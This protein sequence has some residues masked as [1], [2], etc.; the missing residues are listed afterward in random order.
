[1]N[2]G[3][4]RRKK[5][6]VYKIVYTS[7]ENNKVVKDWLIQGFDDIQSRWTTKNGRWCW[8][9]SRSKIKSEYNEAKIHLL[10]GDTVSVTIKNKKL[11]NIKTL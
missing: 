10:T 3:K 9:V 2:M 4:V 7:D 6:R 5:G 1:M 8:I 11:W